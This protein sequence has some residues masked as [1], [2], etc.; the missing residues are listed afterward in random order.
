MPAPVEE[1]LT[2][3]DGI[4]VH[5]SID[6]T[7]KNKEGS[8]HAIFYKLSLSIRKPGSTTWDQESDYDVLIDEVTTINAAN[9]PQ[10]DKAKVRQYLSRE[11]KI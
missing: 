2:K 3:L 5:W 4:T 11:S 8:V 6:P 7:P 1:Y 10:V 9:E